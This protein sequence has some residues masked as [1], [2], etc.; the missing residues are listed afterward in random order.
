MLLLESRGHWGRIRIHAI[1]RIL[2]VML[3]VG[4]RVLDRVL[5]GLCIIR[6]LGVLVLDWDQLVSK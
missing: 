2:L 1:V 4:L 3:V 6:G 5:G